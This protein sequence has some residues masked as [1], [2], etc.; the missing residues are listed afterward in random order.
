MRRRV[1]CKTPGSV[2][3][4]RMAKKIY[5]PCHTAFRPCQLRK[6]LVK[7]ELVFQFMRGWPLSIARKELNWSAYSTTD[8]LM[9]NLNN[10]IKIESWI[11]FHKCF[12]SIP[13]FCWIY[14]YIYDESINL[15]PNQRIDTFS[16]SIIWTHFLL[17]WQL[18]QFVA[19]SFPLFN[20]IK[21]TPT[22]LNY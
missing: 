18:I 17:L 10:K 7:T 22:N 6:L 1:V 12:F 19:S 21:K 14:Y 11:S 20:S 9:L 13:L 15:T 3:I 2:R 16:F 5:G 8:N 4:F